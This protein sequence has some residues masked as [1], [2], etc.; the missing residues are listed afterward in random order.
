MHT[1]GLLQLTTTVIN[2]SLLKIQVFINQKVLLNPSA[3]QHLI[4]TTTKQANV[5]LGNL[6]KSPTLTVQ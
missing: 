2:L 1:P 5:F 4:N 3:N 6:F